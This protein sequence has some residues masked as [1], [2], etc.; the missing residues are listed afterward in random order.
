MAVV[1]VEQE[2]QGFLYCMTVVSEINEFFCWFFLHKIYT[3][4][5]GV[6]FW[7]TN[8]KL[9]IV[10][11]LCWELLMGW[12]TLQLGLKLKLLWLHVEGFCCVTRSL[13]LYLI[14]TIMCQS[15]TIFLTYLVQQYFYTCNVLMTNMRSETW[16]LNWA[17]FVSDYIW[18]SQIWVS[19]WP[20]L[21]L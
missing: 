14:V 15:W 12:R 10:M 3:K 5:Y 1:M 4:I 6:L 21:D 18:P 2:S 19:F 11:L 8:K 17:N 9:M 7:T 20:S 13:D 16:D